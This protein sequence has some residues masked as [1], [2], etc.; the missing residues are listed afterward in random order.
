MAFMSV[1]NIFQ[2]V[3]LPSHS[4]CV[5]G[6]N[7]SYICTTSVKCIAA[8]LSSYLLPN[9]LPLNQEIHLEGALSLTPASPK[10]LTS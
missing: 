10:I 3:Y 5:R 9:Q 2:L 7:V 1:R 8:A 6:Y 4:V